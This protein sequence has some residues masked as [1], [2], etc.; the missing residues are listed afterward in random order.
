METHSEGASPDAS[1]QKGNLSKRKLSDKRQA[2]Y[3]VTFQLR[4][5]ERK[6]VVNQHISVSAKLTK[7]LLV[8]V[9]VFIATWVPSMITTIILPWERLNVITYLKIRNL[10]GDYFH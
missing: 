8:I 6:T 2:K 7:M 5:N 3:H 9:F 1:T 4:Q 10:H